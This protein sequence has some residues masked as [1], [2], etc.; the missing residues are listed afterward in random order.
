MSHTDPTQPTDIQLILAQLVIRI[1]A[2]ERLLVRKGQLSAAELE[3]E[4]K[5]V[6]EEV[7]AAFQ[8]TK[9]QEN[10]HVG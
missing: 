8:A 6:S 7:V 9:P 3:A 4:M 10:S 1:S 5:T 2:M